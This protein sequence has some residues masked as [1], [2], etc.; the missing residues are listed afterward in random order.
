MEKP[1][2]LSATFDESIV[3]AKF[4]LNKAMS[5]FDHYVSTNAGFTNDTPEYKAHKQNIKLIRSRIQEL[6]EKQNMY[7][8]ALRA[9]APKN[10]YPEGP[11]T[12]PRNGITCD[13]VGNKVGD[14]MHHKLHKC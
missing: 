12:K 8:N 7:S 13:R 1:R 14:R 6:E 2:V 4:E 11:F 5:D 9:T 3:N 10:K